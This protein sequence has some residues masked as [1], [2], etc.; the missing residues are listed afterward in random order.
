VTLEGN[1][2]G[3]PVEIACKVT[4]SEEITEITREGIVSGISGKID[5]TPRNNPLVPECPED[6][7]T[8]KEFH[9][10]PKQ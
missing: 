10:V 1:E 3:K 2:P 5:W 6:S 8:K 9:L 4:T 7:G